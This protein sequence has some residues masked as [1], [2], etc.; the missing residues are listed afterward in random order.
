MRDQVLNEGG[1]FLCCCRIVLHSQLDKGQQS[2]EGTG[3]LVGNRVII[4]LEDKVEPACV[5]HLCRKAHGLDLGQESTELGH[6]R[7]VL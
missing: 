7:V 5:R 4:A 3:Y 1:H 2:I 6:H